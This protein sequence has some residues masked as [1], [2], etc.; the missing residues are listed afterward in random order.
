MQIVRNKRYFN[1]IVKEEI[2]GFIYQSMIDSVESY[3]FN[4]TK[5][6][7]DM[8]LNFQSGLSQIFSLEEAELMY[9]G[10]K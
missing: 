7:G 4:F 5:L 10:V 6:Q 9:E 2:A 8:E 3:S 1:R